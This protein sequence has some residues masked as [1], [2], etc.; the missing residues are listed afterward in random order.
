MFL[1]SQIAQQFKCGPSKCSYLIKFGLSE[2]YGGEMLNLVKKKKWD[3]DTPGDHLTPPCKGF[4]K[5]SRRVWSEGE[6]AAVMSHFENHLHLKKLAGKK[7]II[8]CLE[9]EN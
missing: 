4:S 7:E 2:Y 1:D 8:Q 5:F 6:K 3:N 9:R